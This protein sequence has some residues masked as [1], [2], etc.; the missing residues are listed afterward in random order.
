MIQLIIALVTLGFID[1]LN[2]A[3]IATLIILIPMVKNLKYSVIFIWG[4][5]IT[6]FI[7]GISFY[8]G[9]NKL[10][11]SF[12]VGLITRYT[13]EISILG[14]ILGL[15]LLGVGV[16]FSIKV[17]KIIKKKESIKEVN[18]I[19]IENVTPKAIIG[20][21]IISTLSDAPTAIPY[22][23]FISVLLAKELSLLVV[24]SILAIYCIIYIMPM[25]VIYFSYKKF[26]D[27]FQAIEIKT[28]DLINK[29]SVYS[30]PVICF[31]GAMWILSE[32]VVALIGFV[33]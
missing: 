33:H 4:T 3:T 9:I 16:K 1:C 12:I 28:K 27:K 31:I 5:F 17:I 14:I 11:K 21:A 10:I 2:P 32:S 7:V 13:F 22:I 19:K 18:F 6:Y 29:A 15:V 8:Y 24:I 30:I 20:L 25:L 23:G 26:K